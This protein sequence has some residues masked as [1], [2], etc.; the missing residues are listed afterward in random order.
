M[1][2]KN[3]DMAI[4]I[5][6]LVGVAVISMSVFYYF[7]IFLPQSRLL[8]I[9]YDKQI[10]LAEIDQRQKEYIAEY[11][12]KRESIRLLGECL[13]QA[14]EVYSD[15]WELQCKKFQKEENCTLPADVVKT[16]NGHHESSRDECFKRFPQN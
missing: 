16:L 3:I 12:K 7:V 1:K 2:S 15:N 6:I 4:K 8:K 10:Q 14:Q 13:G 11:E 5:L 9:E